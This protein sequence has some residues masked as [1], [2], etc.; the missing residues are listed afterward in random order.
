[1]SF[2]PLP[3]TSRRQKGR[4]GR[5]LTLLSHTFRGQVEGKLVLLGR[6]QLTIRSRWLNE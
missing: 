3:V 5:Y 4:R 2:E 1:M 6:V